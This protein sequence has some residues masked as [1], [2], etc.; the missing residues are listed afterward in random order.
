VV[1]KAAADRPN[2]TAVASTGAIATLFFYFVSL[3]GWDPPPEVVAAITTLIAA[4]GV[5]LRNIL[6][7]R[8]KDGKAKVSIPSS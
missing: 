7:Q 8:R 3:A 4:G 2:T 1:V 6:A 5:E